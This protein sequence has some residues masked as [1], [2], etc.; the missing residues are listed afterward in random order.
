[1]KPSL[2]SLNTRDPLPAISY[3]RTQ[4]ISL[5]TRAPRPSIEWINPAI[6]QY[7]QSTSNHTDDDD[8]EPNTIINELIDNNPDIINGTNNL[9]DLSLLYV[10]SIILS[11]ASQHR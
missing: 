1:M 3:R 9:L 10:K 8:H 6:N 2:P 5:Q 11:S 7:I 4:A